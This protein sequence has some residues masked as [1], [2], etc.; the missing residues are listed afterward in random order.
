M[1]SLAC[2]RTLSQLVN[3]ESPGELQQYLAANKNVNVDDKDEVSF[4]LCIHNYVKI[5]SKYYLTYLYI[6]SDLQYSLQ[7]HVSL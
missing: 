6:K 4:L 7:F 3:S 2:F 1:V 5:T